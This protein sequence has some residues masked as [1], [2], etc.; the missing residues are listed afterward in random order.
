MKNIKHIAFAIVAVIILHA[1]APAEGDFPGSEYMPDMG[2]SVAQEANIH[3][4]Y[5]YNTWDSASVI[6]LKD[7][8][9][10]G[11]PV[12]GT[13][14]RGYAGTFFAEMAEGGP[15]SD[16]VMAQHNGVKGVNNIAVPVNGHVPYYYKDTEPERQRATAELIDNPYPI[17]EDGLA[18][19]ED[20]YNKFCG[21]CHGEKGNGV[22][23][24]VSEENPNVAYPAQPANFL[25]GD[26]LT[27]SNGRYYHAIMY[28]KNVMGGYADKMN[29]E[30]RWQVIHWIRHL[31]AKDQ[32]AEYTAETNTLNPTFG[33]PASQMESL[34]QRATDEAPMPAE[35]E[36]EG[37]AEHGTDESHGEGSHD[38]TGGDHSGDS[39]HGKK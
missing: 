32:G 7:L 6:K 10:P 9:S 8:S 2:H 18:R 4:Y 5:Y 14:P 37:D 16:E 29:Y 23:Y 30:E 36:Q 12:E 21:I 19:G 20:L 11:L 35:G 17:T 26:L 27:A 38:D 31:Q 33:T 22:G 39:S 34:A 1:C 25:L 15:D 24:L 13:M 28:G 3:N